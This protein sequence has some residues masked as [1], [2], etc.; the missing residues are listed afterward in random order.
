EQ[1]GQAEGQLAG[2]EYRQAGLVLE[3]HVQVIQ[4]RLEGLQGAAAEE[5]ERPL[6]QQPGVEA[7]DLRSAIRRAVGEALVGP[8]AVEPVAGVAVAELRAQE[9]AGAFDRRAQVGVEVGT[10]AAGALL[11]VEG[12]GL[13]LDAGEQPVAE[14]YF[15]VVQR[16]WQAPE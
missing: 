4:A 5:R 6:E 8:A 13:C 7:E 14:R 1:L 2:V 3:R 16:A 12:H 11:V 10:L 9:P 15:G